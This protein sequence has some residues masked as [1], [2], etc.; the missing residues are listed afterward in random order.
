MV[1]LDEYLSF[2]HEGIPPGTLAT[3]GKIVKPLGKIVSKSAANAA[4]WTAGIAS[5]T[6]GLKLL[7]LSL[8]GAARKCGA[9]V[10][11][12]ETPG[13]KICI[14]KERINILQQEI[15]IYEN[16]LSKCNNN[17]NP[18]LCKQK[19][20]L[21]IEKAKNKVLIN[22]DRIKQIEGLEE[23]LQMLGKVGVAA[24]GLATMMATDKAVFLLN[25]TFLAA[26]SKE[27]R[28]C[29]IY[30]DGPERNLCIAKA[31]LPALMSKLEKLKSISTKCNNEK[32]PIKCREKIEKQIEK[33]KQEIQ[34]TKDSII[35]YKNEVQ[36][37]KRED[38]LKAAM[39]A[40]S[41]E[42]D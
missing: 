10:L 11:K 4:V 2:L 16:I 31:R 33:T 41:K 36:I 13:V 28:K 39:K 25:R 26:I 15:R 35:S 3:V 1:N 6:A 9:G 23:Q 5:A 7:K 29:G 20:S 19:F 12:K 40:Q 14:A 38:M 27:V 32:D 30:T 18:E 42:T 37:K 24:L 34:I 21:K 8:S 22:Q 17:E